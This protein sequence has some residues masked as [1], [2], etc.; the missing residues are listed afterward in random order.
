MAFEKSYDKIQFMDQ[1]SKQ[2][3]QNTLVLAEEN[4]KMLHKIRGVQKRGTLWQVLKLIVI[5][6]IAL[7]SFY[8][9]E[10][11]LNKIIDLYN[12]VS[13]MQQQINNSPIQDLLKKF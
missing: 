11:Y 8:Y 7:G 12:S 2:L 10:P 9:I 4:N 13:G 1:E 6:G 3:L 5:I